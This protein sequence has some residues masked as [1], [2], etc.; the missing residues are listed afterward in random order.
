MPGYRLALT[1]SFFFKF[2][3]HV[4]ERR[5]ISLKAI[6]GLDAESTLP[7]FSTTQ[8]YRVSSKGQTRLDRGQTRLDRGQT[9]LDRGQTRLDRGQT[10]PDM[11]QTRPD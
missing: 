5:K 6:S 4:A 8:V 10:R 9:R 7:A 2:F 1:L 3:L 11:G